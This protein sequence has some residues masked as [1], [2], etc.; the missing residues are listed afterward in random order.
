MI[1]NFGV[2]EA[3]GAA[4]SNEDG[5]AVRDGALMCEVRYD[6]SQKQKYLEIVDTGHPGIVRRI[7]S[8]YISS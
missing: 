6:D 4:I 7:K 3:E 2:G 8:D 1:L 5:G